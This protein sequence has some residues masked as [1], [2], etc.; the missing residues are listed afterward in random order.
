MDFF[1]RHTAIKLR[2]L[3]IAENLFIGYLCDL[4]V[5]VRADILSMSRKS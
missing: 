3:L 1:H 2:M 5:I 4:L